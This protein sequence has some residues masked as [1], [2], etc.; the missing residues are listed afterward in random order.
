MK[1]RN[2]IPLKLRGYSLIT[3][4]SSE[5]NELERGM[6]LSIGMAKLKLESN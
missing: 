5:T 4:G 6:G 2:K 1:G 3:L